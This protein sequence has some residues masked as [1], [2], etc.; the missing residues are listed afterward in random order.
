MSDT[1]SERAPPSGQ[2]DRAVVLGLDGVPWGLLKDWVEDGHLPNFARLFDEGASG[3]LES[4]T[5]AH[6]ALA[7]P[8]IATGTWPDQHGVYGFQRL[9]GDYT[10]RMNTSGDVSRPALWE[11][12]SPSVTGNVPMT[13]PA[14]EVDGELVTGMMTPRRDEGFTHPAALREEVAEEIPSY[15]IGLDWG[16]YA[17][18]EGE[19]QEDLDDLLV[20]RSALREKLQAREDWRLFFFVYTAPDRLQ[21]LVWNESVLLAWYERLDDVVGEVMDY[22]AANDAMLAVVS[23]HGFGPNETVVSAA[24]VLE[25]AGYLSR[26]EQSGVRGVLANLGIDK[27]GVLAKLERVGVSQQAIVDYVPQGFVDVAAMQ[28]PGEHGLYDVDHANTTAFVHGAG[29]V[30][31]NDTGRFDDGVVDPSERAAV[32]IELVDLFEGVT[33]PETGD[34][35]FDVA[36]G[37]YLFPRDDDAPDLVLSGRDGYEVLTMLTEETFHDA[38][39]KAAG[40]RPE[41]VFFAWGPGVEAGARTEDA[42]VVDVAPTVLHA[43]GEPVPDHVDGRVLTDAFDPESAPATRDVRRVDLDY[44]ASGGGDDAGNGDVSD[45]EERLRGLGYIE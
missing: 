32:K 22:A 30:Y 16:E 21:H 4:T 23:D 31:V 45:V 35:V 9:E 34:R 17:D 27:D 15:E 40:H 6:T 41:G 10:H 7:W 37:D 20:A 1:D 36:D 42:T 25:D 2:P 8:S 43:V 19:F 39:T 38:E 14:A 26:R 29:N 13:Y 28:V 12:V 3:V 33:D 44:D 11:L 5:P 24:T 18:R